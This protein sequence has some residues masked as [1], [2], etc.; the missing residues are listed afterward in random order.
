MTAQ[1][2]IITFM[3]D[4]GKRVEQK[5]FFTNEDPY[6]Y[7]TTEYLELCAFLDFEIEIIEE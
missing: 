5:E 3:N 7:A 1:K 2:Y 6:S 4:S